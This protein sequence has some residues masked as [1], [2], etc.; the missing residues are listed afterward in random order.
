MA[1]NTEA[2]RARW[3]VLI[4]D[5]TASGQS[6][7]AFCR[8]RGLRDW[9]FYDWKK[10]LRRAAAALNN[11]EPGQTRVFYQERWFSMERGDLTVSCNL[12]E[13]ARRFPVALGSRVVLS[14]R[15]AV[16]VTDGAVMLPPDTAVIVSRSGIRIGRG[17]GNA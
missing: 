7:A 17:T 15:E 4:S 14:S 9:Q 13:T 8:E 10:R 11:G 5:Q 1:D 6:V 2:S 16:T 12:G 3:R